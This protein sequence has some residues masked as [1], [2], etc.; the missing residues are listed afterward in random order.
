[1]EVFAF[2]VVFSRRLWP[3]TLHFDG[4]GGAGEAE[5]RTA[6][7]F[8]KRRSIIVLLSGRV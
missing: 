3:L 5:S 1:M 8:D 2:V 6:L 7:A 4:D